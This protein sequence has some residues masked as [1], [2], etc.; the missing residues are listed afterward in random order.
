M[1]G[2]K[3]ARGRSTSKRVQN[4]VDDGMDLIRD[5]AKRPAMWGAAVSVALAALAGFAAY[6]NS[7]ESGGRRTR[8]ALARTRKSRLSAKSA[9]MR[10]RRQKAE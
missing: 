3:A 1:F 9:T 5:S 4:W 8:S 6:H 2:I 10:R 7:D